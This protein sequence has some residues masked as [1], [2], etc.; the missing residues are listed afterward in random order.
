MTAM[1]ELE[2]PEL[3]PG[4]DPSA[5][6][7]TEVLADV[8][9]DSYGPADVIRHA[10]AWEAVNQRPLKLPIEME[11]WEKYAKRKKQFKPCRP[12][13]ADAAT[14]AEDVKR[15]LGADEPE[16]PAALKAHRGRIRELEDALGRPPRDF[17]IPRVPAADA[18][19]VSLR[20]FKDIAEL[21]SWTDRAASIGKE[22]DIGALNL[23]SMRDP[24][25]E[26]RAAAMTRILELQRP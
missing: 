15:L 21:E 6:I 5:E 12:Y 23:L 22:R 3:P 20:K 19:V 4:F 26:V 11:S 2:Y 17:S 25:E 1:P 24:R 16:D 13:I 18:D 7:A 14:M 9:G 8:L 10:A